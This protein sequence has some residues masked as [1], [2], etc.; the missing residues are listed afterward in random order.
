MEIYGIIGRY[1]NEFRLEV[2]A[3]ESM[4]QGWLEVLNED[5]DEDEKYKSFEEA[6]NEPYQ[7]YLSNDEGFLV[8][9]VI[10][11]LDNNDYYTEYYFDDYKYI[12]ADL[13]D[14]EI[15]EIDE[16][17]MEWKDKMPDQNEVDVCM[18][19]EF[20]KSL[21]KDISWLENYSL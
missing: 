11:N 5:C 13:T 10:R 19:S 2:K 4:N 12:N 7:C 1:K 15:K 20:L 17:I 6:M 14:E 8:M 3:T 18:G 9:E 21:P 16:F